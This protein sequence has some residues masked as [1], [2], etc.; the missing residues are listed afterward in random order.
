MATQNAINGKSGTVINKIRLTSSAQTSTP[1]NTTPVQLTSL[2]YSAS[3]AT[4][5]LV[6]T[7][8]IYSAN[9]AAFNA[10]LFLLYE[11]STLL[12]SFSS[13]YTLNGGSYLLYQQAAGTT[14]ST[15]YYI[16]YGTHG[17]AGGNIYINQFDSSGSSFSGS[18]SYTFTITEELP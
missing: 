8:C 2:S 17:G 13:N 12:T 6:F 1:N 4:N 7:F 9:N 3:N 15:T 5:I 11:G 18:L 14:S 16:Y 10:A